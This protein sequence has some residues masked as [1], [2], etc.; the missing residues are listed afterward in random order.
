VCRALKVTCLARDEETLSALKLASVGAVWELTPG[1]V[2]A[3]EALAQIS[4]L[5]SHVF[6]AFGP[7]EEAV[8]R[9]RAEHRSLRIVTDRPTVGADVVVSSLEEVRD[10][11]AGLPKP[12][13]PVRA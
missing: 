4:E 3:A 2:E 12:G 10:A 7:F 5:R 9:A 11:I 13:G 6:V 8:A 1:A